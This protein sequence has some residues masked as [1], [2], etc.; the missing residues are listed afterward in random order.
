MESEVERQ[1][2]MGLISFTFISET[3]ETH[4]LYSAVTEEKD[5]CHHFT[6]VNI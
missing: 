2:H 3:S 6:P 4:H 1:T 5:P